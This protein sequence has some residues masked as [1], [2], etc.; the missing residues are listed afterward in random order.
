LIEQEQIVEKKISELLDWEWTKRREKVLISSLFYAILVSSFLLP[1]QGWLPA[2][3]NPFSLLLL[4]FIIFSA[5]FFLS[6]PW[7]ER[8][9]Q[10]TL[11]FVDSSLDL[12]A[13][14]LTAREILDRE[15]RR[16][17]ELLVLREAGD[18]LKGVDP[19]R[20]FKRKYSW[21]F[22]LT[23]ILL[24]FW[25]LSVW[26]DVGPQLE[27]RLQQSSRL[28][29]ARRLKAFS[30]E[31]QERS[32]AQ[33][34]GQSLQAAEKLEDL[35]EKN[36]AGKLSEKALNENLSGMAGKLGEMVS[37]SAQGTP[38]QTNGKE[39][40][41]LRSEIDAFKGMLPVQRQ[42]QGEAGLAPELLG[43]LAALPHL[44]G[45]VEKHFSQIDRM[46]DRELRDF[47][48]QLE[49][50]VRAQTDRLT[51]SEMQQYLE[52]LLQEIEG[53]TLESTQQ[54][55]RAMPGSLSEG[56]KADAKGSAVGT[57][58]GSRGETESTLPS[59]QARVPRQLKG[60]LGEGKS[61]SLPLKIESPPGKSK[62]PQEEMIA[63]YQRR[64]EEDLASEKI[65]EGLKDTVRKYFLSL[66][67]SEKQ[68]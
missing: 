55:G 6:R 67:K 21:D 30:S 66:G 9:S 27:H 16:A 44:S 25:F 22:F 15:E 57:E 45:E 62:V 23:P 26:F 50:S 54:A 56:E 52:Q 34:L 35:A 32:K 48:E 59:F 2:W 29:T 53:E 51:L 8:D 37:Q 12:A 64:A 28:S 65:P 3:L 19:K 17:T 38:T 47:L 61:A 10:R 43:K 41:D 11:W 63:D 42:G 60:Q 46:G 49:R 24:V 13:R 31:I 20:L 36:L 14:T 7:R 58:A 40:G 5:F 68:K 33:G 4:L 18:K 39:L 1:A